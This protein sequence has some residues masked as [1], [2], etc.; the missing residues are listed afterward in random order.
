MIDFR[1]KDQ[2]M[3]ILN[4]TPDSFSDGGQHYTLDDALSHA[5][6]LIKEGAAILDIGGQSTRPGYQE[7]TPEIEAQRILPVIRELVKRTDVPI[8]VD[9]YFPEVAAAAIEAGAKII[10]D[11]KGLDSPGMLEVLAAAPQ[12]GIVI[13]HSRP[14]RKE[15][16]VK[17]D[18]QAF[19]LEQ[20][21]R[22]REHNIAP[23]R[24]CFDPGIGF[25]KT[26]EENIQILQQPADF[27]FRDFPLLYGVSRKRTIQHLIGDSSPEE[28]DYAS[29]TASLFAAQA[30]VEI[31]RVHEVKGMVDALTVWHRLSH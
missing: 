29:V 12:V 20:F 22:C 28:R 13:M 23:E 27:R 9:T 6:L 19:Y 14:R 25:G 5:E 8:S 26:P 2:V 16:P 1:K 18:I 15:L 30:G 24:L 11:I 17:E 7:V 31:L 3:G 10:N 21:E 4:V